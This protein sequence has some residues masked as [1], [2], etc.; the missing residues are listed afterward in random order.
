MDEEII[1]SYLEGIRTPQQPAVRQRRTGRELQR[2][3]EDE[4]IRTHLMHTSIAKNFAVGSE[5]QSSMRGKVTYQNF[6]VTKTVH[7]SITE[8]Q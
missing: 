7:V 3:L 5:A 8:S 6:L 1:R 2:S 4:T